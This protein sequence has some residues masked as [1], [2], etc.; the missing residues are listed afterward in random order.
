MQLWSWSW[1]L[2][3][4]SNLPAKRPVVA[5]RSGLA[6]CK[7]FPPWNDR[8]TLE[9][10]HRSVKLYYVVI[11][12]H[13]MFPITL[14]FLDWAIRHFEELPGPDVQMTT[15]EAAGNAHTSSEFHDWCLNAQMPKYGS[16]WFILQIS[17]HCWV[18]LD[19]GN[20]LYTRGLKSQCQLTRSQLW[21]GLVKVYSSYPHL[22]NSR[23]PDTYL[24]ELSI[25][26]HIYL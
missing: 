23:T 5:Q 3:P 17:L 16:F 9:T 4:C 14:G 7:V 15:C 11:S 22:R 6:R 25:Y 19:A 2:Q 18:E 20:M 13:G 8:Q 24:N 10:N 1:D 12:A 26:I 21:R